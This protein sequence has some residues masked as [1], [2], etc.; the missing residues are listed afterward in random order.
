[1]TTIEGN[2]LI[3]EFM[4]IRYKIQFGEVR[5]DRRHGRAIKYESDWSRLMPAIDR[6]SHYFNML[7]VDEIKPI[8]EKAQAIWKL[9][10]CAPS[11]SYVWQTV[12]DFIQWY[13][14]NSKP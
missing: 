6:I 8:P 10:I 5:E 4:G 3:A 7:S 11:I 14:Q 13:N 2:K 12:V 9:K 1:M